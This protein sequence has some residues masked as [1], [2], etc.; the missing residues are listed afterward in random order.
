MRRSS[1]VRHHRLLRNKRELTVRNFGSMRCTIWTCCFLWVGVATA[2]E[3]VA[4]LRVNPALAGAALPGPASAGISKTTALNLPFFEDF[5]D[6]SQY[7]ASIRWS[8]AQVYINNTMGLS[9]VSRGVATFDAL[10]Q[11]GRPYD[12]ISSAAYRYADSLTSQTFD[13]SDKLPGD[14][15]YLSFFYQPQGRGFAPEATDSLL[16][17]FRASNG[18]YRRQWGAAGSTVQPF[19]QVM[20][21]VRDTAFFYNGFRFRFVNKASI[22]LNDDVWNLD[23][24][25]FAAGR[26]F[27][28]TTIEDP[29]MTMQ[30]SPFLADYVSMPYRQF[31]AA[32]GAERSSSMQYTARPNS[33]GTV[34]VADGYETRVLGGGVSGSGSGNLTMSGL[35]ETT[36]QFPNNAS[37]PPLGGLNDRVVFQNRYFFGNAGGAN[38]TANDTIVRQTIFDNYLAYDDGTAERSYFLNLSPSLP[39]KVAIEHRLNV[40]DTLRGVAVLF[41]QQ[42]PTA[43]G[44]F[45]TAVVYRSLEGVSGAAS[46]DI[47][48]QED[49]LQP[50]F[51]DTVNSP[52]TYRFTQPVPLSAGRFYIGLTQPALSGSDSLYYALD[53]NRVGSNHLY[54]NV[55]NQWQGSLISGALIVRPLLGA[56]I[57][58]TISEIEKEAG[59]GFSIF[60]NPSRDALQIEGASGGPVR[61]RIVDLQGRIVAGGGAASGAQLEVARLVPGVYLIQIATR[62][63]WSRPQRWVKL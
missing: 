45:F 7:P 57:P 50:S 6:S 36:R 5:L 20:I 33:T 62:T 10:N 26:N 15:I 18:Q 58:L 46:D 32:S 16:L 17:Y 21:A 31:I 28:D 23:Y 63:G 38:R 54:F 9:P 47:V 13:L 60:P 43:A 34:S 24:I 2:Q 48:Y 4:P 3:S 1:R 55:L 25:R 30:P 56:E 49:F 44:K 40:S 53:V 11:R 41:G 19:R 27:A 51:T 39:G 42:V 61:Y 37:V 35:N 14:S 12:T 52:Q 22:N 8:D 59:P 29:A